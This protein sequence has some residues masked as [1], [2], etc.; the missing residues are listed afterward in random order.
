MNPYKPLINNIYVTLPNV[1]SIDVS[2]P[3]MYYQSMKLK[4][5]KRNAFNNAIYSTWHTCDLS[6][7]KHLETVS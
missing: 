4:A 3:L 6:R 7:H 1:Y 5:S 2:L